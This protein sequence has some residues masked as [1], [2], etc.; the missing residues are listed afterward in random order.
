MP[1][2]CSVLSM[3]LPCGLVAS[4]CGLI[5][6]MCKKGH[7]LSAEIEHQLKRTSVFLLMVTTASNGSHRVGMELDTYISLHADQQMSASVGHERMLVSV[8]LEGVTLPPRVR[9][10]NWIDA[11]GRPV[12]QVADEIARMV[13]SSGT[14]SMVSASPTVQTPQERVLLAE[15][16]ATPVRLVK[17][18]FAA[19][20]INGV[21]VI[22]PPLAHVPAGEFL[23]GSDKLLDAQTYDDEL[24]QYRI[25]VGAYAIGV[26]PVTVAEYACGVK[27]GAVA[28]PQSY[29]FPEDSTWTSPAWSGKELSWEVQQRQR[30]DHPVVI[31]SWVEVTA[32]VAWLAKVTGQMWRLPTEAEWEKGL[33]GWTGASI[34]GAINGTRPVRIRMMVGRVR[35]HRWGSMRPK[36][37]P[38]HMDCTMSPATCGSGRVVLSCPIPMT[39]VKAKLSVIRQATECCVAVRG[40]VFLWVRARPA[41]TNAGRITAVPMWASGLCSLRTLVHNW[42]MCQKGFCLSQVQGDSGMTPL[43]EQWQ[44]RAV[45]GNVGYADLTEKPSKNE[46]DDIPDPGLS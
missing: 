37:M 28:A 34:H 14:P 25:P 18:G 38:A 5:W 39:E 40:S 45:S 2:T 9:G 27:A 15:A 29:T 26:Y 43:A 7:N 31:V 22:L 10:Y 19:W 24:P 8:R 33:A 13:H 1:T 6:P 44:W 3:L 20:R 4:K 32:Y 23:M 30:Q 46:E 35:L 16:A 21:E 11:V 42:Q 41:A 17:L 12:E 36:R